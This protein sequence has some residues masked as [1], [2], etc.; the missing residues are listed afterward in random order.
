LLNQF[1]ADFAAKANIPAPEQAV[2]NEGANNNN[3]RGH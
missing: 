3:E 2:D 1:W